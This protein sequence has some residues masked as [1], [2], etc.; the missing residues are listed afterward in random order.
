MCESGGKGI[1]DLLCERDSGLRV[2]ICVRGG[3]G[4]G[5]GGAV[6]GW[7]GGGG[8]FNTMAAIVYQ[9][10]SSIN[11]D[12]PG[13]IGLLVKLVSRPPVPPLA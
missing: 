6:E 10:P 3:R 4:G 13:L 2:C 7:L 11:Q 5:D 1:G 12:D 8:C 9:S